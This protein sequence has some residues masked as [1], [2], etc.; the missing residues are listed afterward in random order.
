MTPNRLEKLTA[1]LNKRQSNITVILENVHDTMNI[2]AVMRSCDAIGIKDLFLINTTDKP[3]KK[4]GKKSSAGAYK[5]L[6]CH[7]FS[8][9][10]ECVDV[11]RAEYETILTT[12]LHNNATGLYEIDFTKKIALAFGNEHAGI[13]D[14]LEQMA[15]GNFTIPQV[16]MVQSLN[17]SVACAVTLYEAYR[18]K[19]HA[20]HYNT[21]NLAEAERETILQA[22]GTKDKEK[23]RIKKKV[24]PK[25]PF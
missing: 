23:F 4:W 14:T 10:K 12:K 17:I 13:T 2:S 15:D 5:W 22:W 21:I 3:Y 18:Q 7:I 11:V 25:M 16:G 20:G 24:V 6:N 9:Q 8:S 1:V 19:L